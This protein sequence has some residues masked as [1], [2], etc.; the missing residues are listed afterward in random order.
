MRAIPKNPPRVRARSSTASWQGGPS[1][2][3]QGGPSARGESKWTAPRR[4]GRSSRTGTTNSHPR[5]SD[6][7][8]EWPAPKIRRKILVAGGTRGGRRASK[9]RGSLDVLLFLKQARMSGIVADL[10]CR[11]HS[12]ASCPR[13]APVLAS[14]LFAGGTRLSWRS[15]QPG[16]LPDACRTESSTASAICS[17]SSSGVCCS[18]FGS[19]SF[20]ASSVILLAT[21]MPM[22]RSE[23]WTGS[24]R[25]A[26]PRLSGL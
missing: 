23:G 17:S 5:I 21:R 22:R 9:L 16:L 3:Q 26:R 11:H 1:G 25:P 4:R 7:G 8:G 10:R 15:A 14:D 13:C 2:R 18:R 12:A 19:S 6:V 24:C 20:I